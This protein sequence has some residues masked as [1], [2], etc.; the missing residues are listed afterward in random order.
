MSLFAF[1]VNEISGL[2]LPDSR[3][4]RRRVTVLNT[5]TTEWFPRR[6]ASCSGVFPD[7]SGV[8]SNVSFSVAATCSSSTYMWKK[9]TKCV[10]TLEVCVWWG[11]GGCVRAC[12]RACV[13]VCVN[14]C[15]RACIYV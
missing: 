5:L 13:D 6:A 9:R 2:R 3:T 11:E 1:L 8:F 10:S 15:M 14:V 12:V 7:L 4:S